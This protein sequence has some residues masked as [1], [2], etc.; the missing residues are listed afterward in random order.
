MNGL[1][2]YVPSLAKARGRHSSFTC[3][4]LEP[5]PVLVVLD[6]LGGGLGT[7][8]SFTRGDAQKQP[9]IYTTC[10]QFQ[11]YQRPLRTPKSRSSC[12]KTHTPVARLDRRGNVLRSE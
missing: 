6:T 10:A 5:V 7:H 11:L 2:G 8:Q 9:C 1:R 4:L 12:R 3:E